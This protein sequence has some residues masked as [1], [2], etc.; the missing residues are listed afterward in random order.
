MCSPGHTVLYSDILPLVS[1]LLPKL[2][3]CPYAVL[4]YIH[5][6]VWTIKSP[7]HPSFWLG[8]PTTVPAPPGLMPGSIHWSSFYHKVNKWEASMIKYT[9]VLHLSVCFSSGDKPCTV[10]VALHPSIEPTVVQ[11]RLSH[12]KCHHFNFLY[13]SWDPGKEAEN[14]VRSAEKR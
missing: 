14:G 2:M 3:C 4:L 12:R 1:G 10:Y 8:C 6:H 11:S 7:V 5:A 9:S 13:C